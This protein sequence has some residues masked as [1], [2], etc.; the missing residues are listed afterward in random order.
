[1][2]ENSQTFGRVHEIYRNKRINFFIE[3]DRTLKNYAE[4][5]LIVMKTQKNWPKN[6]KYQEYFLISY[7]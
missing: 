3:Y 1:M 2:L 5:I 7:S 6:A 4:T